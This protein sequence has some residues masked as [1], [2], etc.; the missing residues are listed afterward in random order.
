MAF[1]GTVRSDSVTFTFKPIDLRSS[2]G[3]SAEG[4]PIAK[5]APKKGS[6]FASQDMYFHHSD[7][8]VS[9]LTLLVKNSLQVSDRPASCPLLEVSAPLKVT[10]PRTLTPLVFVSAFHPTILQAAHRAPTPPNKKHFG[11]ISPRKLNLKPSRRSPYPFAK[12]TPLLAKTMMKATSIQ[13]PT[14]QAPTR[15]PTDILYKIAEFLPSQ[16]S[17]DLKIKNCKEIKSAFLSL[18]CSNGRILKDKGLDTAKQHLERFA[19][20]ST[21]I[22]FAH[23][24][25]SKEIIQ[26]IAARAHVTRLS[27]SHCTFKPEAV[28]AIASIPNLRDIALDGLKHFPKS[29][30]ETLPKE[31][32][33][34]KF[35]WAAGDSVDETVPY[36]IGHFPNLQVLDLTGCQALRDQHLKGLT[37]LTALQE[38]ILNQCILITD[39][40]LQTIAQCAAIARLDL[41]QCDI[42]GGIESLK[43]LKNLYKLTLDHLTLSQNATNVQSLAE[44]KS[45]RELYLQHTTI[46]DATCTTISKV[47]QVTKIDLNYATGLTESGL[48]ALQRLPHLTC[49]IIKNA[50]EG[51]SQ[52][53]ITREKAA[54]KA[55]IVVLE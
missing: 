24:S 4:A 17:S 50:L 2:E 39:V 48:A 11:R 31:I 16:F 41:S 51:I 45:L 42:K 19:S 33:R 53:T 18:P 55:S 29:D 15:L 6:M 52:G 23:E 25:I 37:S 44:I 40:A 22:S 46:D 10:K 27:F 26:K 12:P 38:F 13:A 49:L 8:S 1:S 47:T 35:S 43:A 28:A 7:I 54:K 20:K 9:S 5:P 3:A 36:I 21:H 34:L 32:T 14:R 30:L